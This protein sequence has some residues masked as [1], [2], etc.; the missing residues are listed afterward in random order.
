[1]AAWILLVAAL[2]FPEGTAP[3][4][5]ID[6]LKGDRQSGEL[7]SLDASSAVL[8]TGDVSATVP[9]ADVLG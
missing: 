2:W 6:T 7:V 3:A 1:M 5:E 8:K 4:V 9:L